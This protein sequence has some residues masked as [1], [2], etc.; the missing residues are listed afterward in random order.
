MVR[1]LTREFGIDKLQIMPFGRQRDGEVVQASFTVS[2]EGLFQDIMRLFDAFERGDGWTDISHVRLMAMTGA[3]KER[4]VR[5]TM[6][7]HFFALELLEP[8]RGTSE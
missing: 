6:T 4:R 2:G 8:E 3:G 7:M 5:M 1:S